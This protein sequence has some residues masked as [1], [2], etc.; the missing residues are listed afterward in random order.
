MLIHLFILPF[1]LFLPP[2]RAKFVPDTRL[3]PTEEIAQPTL[4]SHP[5][6]TPEEKFSPPTPEEAERIISHLLPW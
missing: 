4:S 6:V 5:D 2:S 3:Q 1:F